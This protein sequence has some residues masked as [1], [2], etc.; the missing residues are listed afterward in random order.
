VENFHWIGT[1]LIIIAWRNTRIFRNRTWAVVASVFVAHVLLVTLFGGAALERYLLPV[2]PLFFIAVGAAW[3][4]VPSRWRGISQAA[5]FVGLIVCLFWNP[6]W[7]FPFE[8]NLAAVDFVRLHAQAAEYI[9]Q[10]YSDKLVASAWPFPDA[11]RRPEFGYVTRSIAV[12][13]IEN[14]HRDSVL[15]LKRDG[16]PVLVTYS[17]TWEPQTGIVRIP[18]IRSLL[19]RYYEYEPQVTPS[20]IQQDLGLYPRMRWE[21]RG[22]WIEAEIL[23][24]RLESDPKP[25]TSS[26]SQ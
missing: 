13:G 18:W 15:A 9:E 4:T 24:R 11:L 26:R 3:S 1:I 10:N 25:F 14:F 22:Q 21:R 20:E 12:K 19:A 5:M 7:P 23:V 16:V 2:I 6:P 17:R 8:N